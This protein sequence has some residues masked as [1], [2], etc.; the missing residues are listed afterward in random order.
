MVVK[1][2][3]ILCFLNIWFW[4]CRTLCSLWFFSSI[5]LK[6]SIL[7]S[8][9]TLLQLLNHYIVRSTLLMTLDRICRK[10]SLKC[11]PHLLEHLGTFRKSFLIFSFLC[12]S[13]YILLQFGLVWNIVLCGLMDFCLILFVAA[14]ST[15][16]RGVG[17]SF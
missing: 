2:P 6:N 13:P 17:M 1:H 14:K 16:L 12:L 3:S 7:Y 10:S 5:K 4:F 15:S 9:Y 8:C 11:P